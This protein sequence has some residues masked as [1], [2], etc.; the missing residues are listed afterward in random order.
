MT[1][2]ARAD[3]RSQTPV[4]LPVLLPFVALAAVLSACATPPMAE[5]PAPAGPTDAPAAADEREYPPLLRDAPIALATFEHP[6][7]LRVNTPAPDPRVGLAPG[8]FDAEEAIWNL[9]MI[10]TTPPEAPFVG[11]TNSD[12]AFTG[13]YAI[14]GN[15]DG[16]QVWD[17]SD[18]TNP[19]SVV[20]YVCPASQSDV[21]VYENLLFR[22]R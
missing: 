22:S 13:N 1:Q 8:L 5:A 21:S 7:G 10:S 2:I 16:V 9:R 14:Q 18:P 20:T 11:R 12:L 15:Y 4:R 19:T 17:I 3:A 6:A